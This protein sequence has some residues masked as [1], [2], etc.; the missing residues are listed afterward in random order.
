[1]DNGIT[2]NDLITVYTA[3]E[4]EP[5]KDHAGDVDTFV[6]EMNN[7]PSKIGCKTGVDAENSLTS[8]GKLNGIGIR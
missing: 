8:L 7:S 6:G 3:P 4:P 1:M 2:D 5:T